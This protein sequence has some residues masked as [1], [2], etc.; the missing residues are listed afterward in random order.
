VDVDGRGAREALA[1]GFLNPSPRAPPSRLP[2]P[3]DVILFSV[4]WYLRYNLSYRDLEELLAEHDVDVS[5]PSPTD[6]RLKNG[7]GECP[8]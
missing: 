7:L 8:E 5:K 2:I 6:P 4:R 1:D 3:S